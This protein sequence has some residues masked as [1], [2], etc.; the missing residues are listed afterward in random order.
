[1]ASTTVNQAESLQPSLVTSP[2]GSHLGCHQEVSSRDKLPNTKH[3]SIHSC[4]VVTDA[5]QSSNLLPAPR[6]V[7]LLLLLLH[8]VM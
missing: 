8:D 7:L 1:M 5:I 3:H 4:S 6:A 2:C